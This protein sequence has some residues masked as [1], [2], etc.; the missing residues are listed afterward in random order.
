MSTS[1]QGFSDSPKDYDIRIENKKVGAG[2]RITSDRPLS[3]VAYWSIKTVLAIEPFQALS[4]AP[5]AEFTWNINYE[6]Y[7]LPK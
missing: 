4:I 2:M 7:T 3:N 1:F 5:G 6:Y